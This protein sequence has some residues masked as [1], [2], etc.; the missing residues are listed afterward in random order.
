MMQFAFHSVWLGAW[1][2]V[3]NANH[4]EKS[5]F[6]Q[7]RSSIWER[8]FD[9]LHM[10]CAFVQW[11]FVSHGLCICAISMTIRFTWFVQLC[12]FSIP[13]WC[14]S[15]GLCNFA[16]SICGGMLN[17]GW[18]DGHVQ[19]HVWTSL[20]FKINVRSHNLPP[21]PTPPTPSFLDQWNSIGFSI[22]ALYFPL[23]NKEKKTNKKP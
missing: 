5:I 16:I 20:W 6:S 9:A 15:H 17:F 1:G 18:R 10:V 11:Q 2:K 19:P 12:N 14:S 3:R 4:D 8:S 13:I 21:P 7:K 23:K 22:P